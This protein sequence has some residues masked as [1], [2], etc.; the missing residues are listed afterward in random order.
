MRIAPIH[1]E[2]DKWQHFFFWGIGQKSKINAAQVCNGSENVVKIETSLTFLQGVV[3]F[4]TSGI[5]NPRKIEIYCTS[6]QRGNR[7]NTQQIIINNN[8]NNNNNNSSNERR[9]RENFRD[10]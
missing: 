9:S 6:E 5:Y 7:N 3:S 8:N 1:H 2:E 10:R 4:F